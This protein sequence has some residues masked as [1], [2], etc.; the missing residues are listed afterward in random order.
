M[1][2]EFRTDLLRATATLVLGASLMLTGCANDL[3][4]SSAE[5]SDEARAASVAKAGEI[6]DADRVLSTARQVEELTGDFAV[7]LADEAAG[8]DME[9]GED[10]TSMPGSAIELSAGARIAR[11]VRGARHAAR[12]LAVQQDGLAKAI[13]TAPGD[14]LFT[15]TET[16]LDG[17]QSV[18]EVYQGEPDAVVRVLRVTTWP[19]GNLL[20]DSIRDE[21]FVD[22]GADYDSEADD[23]WLSLESAIAFKGGATLTRTIDAR[24]QGGLA[25]DVRVEMVSR[26][27]PRPNHPRLVDVVTT[28]T[29]DLHLL[30]EEDDDRFVSIERTTRLSGTAHDGG[31]PRVIESLAPEMPVAEGEEPCGGELSREIHFRND[32]AL[33]SWIDSAMWA[34]EGGGNLSRT[35]TYADGGVD[36]ITLSENAQGIVTLSASNRD[37]ASVDGSYDPALGSFEITTTYPQGSDPVSEAVQGT[38]TEDETEWQLDAQITYAD[39]FVERNHLE[40]QESGDELRLAGTHEGRDETVSFELQSNRDETLQSGWVENDREERIE[41]TLET[42]TDGSRLLDFVATEPGVRV[43]GHLEVDPDGCGNGTLEVTE[44]GNTVTITIEYCEG[45]DEPVLAGN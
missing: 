31:M 6:L 38:V 42:L 14:L 45:D 1:N 19:N 8:L 40:G 18:F 9:L 3:T 34:C 37:G 30:S 17:S 43:V 13:V 29:A 41:F 24:E 27:A 4:D 26:Y 28:L 10:I 25:D 21:I 16:N 2:R 12:E 23:V 35:V 5:I 33:A 22:R 36:Q 44:D 32:R 39:G 20:L 7:G 15:F 11:T